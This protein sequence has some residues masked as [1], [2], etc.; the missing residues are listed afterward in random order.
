MRI[1][2]THD[3]IILFHVKAKCGTKT[4]TFFYSPKYR[5]SLFKNS[6]H[7]AMSF[8]TTVGDDFCHKVKKEM[9]LH[10][11][12][13]EKL[14]DVPTNIETFYRRN[15]LTPLPT[16]T[17]FVPSLPAGAPFRVSV[18]SWHDPVPGAYTKSRAKVFDDIMFEAR[19]FIDGRLAG[20]AF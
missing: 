3:R 19:V 7:P 2:L 15:A 11:S 17:S 5:K 10:H 13:L 16:V 8:T 12:T 4:G 6:K 1:S 18:H 9:A 14:A 20:Q